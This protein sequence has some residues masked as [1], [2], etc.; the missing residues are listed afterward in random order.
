MSRLMSWKCVSKQT[1]EI[2]N[3]KIMKRKLY[4][5]SMVLFA[6]L[7]VMS[8]EDL[9][10]TYD[11]FAGDGAIRYLGKCADVQVAP[12]WERLRVVWKN[13]LDVAVKHTK[14]TWQAESDDQPSVRLIERGEINPE[15]E[16]MDTVYLEGLT[17]EIY[18]ITVSNISADSTESLVETLYARP[19]TSEH[20][21]LRSFTRG[22]VNFYPLG[23]KLAVVLDEDNENLREMLLV[24]TGTDG[25]EHTWDI[26]E[27]MTDSIP[28]I[29]GMEEYGYLM[30]ESMQLLP[31]DGN[32]GIDFSQPLIV[33]R[34]GRLL[35]CI[36]D[37]IFA[38]ETLSMD[39]RIL[40]V[41]FTQ[42]LTRNYGPD[43]ASKDLFNTLETIELDY[44]MASFQDLFYFSNLK[45]VVLGQN[46]FMAAG[47]EDENPSYT[48]NNY[49]SLM[50]LQ[51]LKETRPDFSVERYNSQYFNEILESEML[52]GMS[53]IDALLMVGAIDYS[54]I[55]DVRGYDANYEF[56]PD[57]TPLDT[58]GWQIT[59]TDTVYN[60]YKKNGAAWLLDDD[61]TTYFE[62]GQTLGVTIFEVNID[63]LTPRVLHGFKVVQPVRDVANEDEL[64]DEL[65]YLLPNIEIEVSEN[66][67]VWEQATYDEA[68]ISIGDALGETTFIKIPEELQ[69]RSVRYIRIT[70]A[71]RHTSD[72]S[73]GTPLYSL[74]L[75]DVVPY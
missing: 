13:N 75:A 34:K 37:I 45:K 29:P 62:P 49:N 19:Y 21:D 22:I 1:S 44:D 9:E 2:Q 26:K 31:E 11:E 61:V 66:G 41:G 54:L 7:F 18:T 52:G 27:H 23:D 63:M 74:R 57:Y 20:E 51:F 33:K 24:F 3:Y 32:V 70:M 42:W 48:D 68:G 4:Y 55:T 8:C 71:N 64:A 15:T 30:R 12:G 46:R 59:C 39:E 60:G 5:Y 53:Y 67:Y 69:S 65:A 50:T 16:L 6:A 40:S 36:D 72:I 47:H 14:I 56:M 43:W 73:G 35:N 58:T 38:D 25:Q 10:D 17:D 28:L